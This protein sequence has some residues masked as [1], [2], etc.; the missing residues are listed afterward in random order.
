MH[1]YK[2]GTYIVIY[3]FIYLFIH[4][5]YKFFYFIHYLLFSI[6]LKNQIRIMIVVIRKLVGEAIKW[7][8]F[9]IH[10][11]VVKCY[12][13]R[14]MSIYKILYFASPYYFVWYFVIADDNSNSFRHCESHACQISARIAYCR[15]DVSS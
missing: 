4:S 14:N 1:A 15:L 3:S 12:Q 5:L 11:N 13:Y 7:N 8:A 2:K 10:V 9:D 6:G